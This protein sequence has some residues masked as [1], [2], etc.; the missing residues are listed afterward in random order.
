MLGHH[1]HAYETF[2]WWAD[3]SPPLLTK[4]KKQHRINNRTTALESH[5]GYWYQ[6]FAQDP[7]FVEAQTMLSSQGGFLTIAMYHHRKTI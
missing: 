6:I 4:K 2:H 3:D 7:A 1:R 5:P